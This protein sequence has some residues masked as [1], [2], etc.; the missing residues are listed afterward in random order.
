VEKGLAALMPI[1]ADVPARLMVVGDGPERRAL[2]AMAPPNVDFLGSVP[3]SEVP[4]LLRGAR[5]LVLPSI[6]YEGA[7]RTVTEAF[8]A[9]VPVVGS[10][11]GAIG[12]MVV[13][14]TTGTLATPRVRDEWVSAVSRMMDD[15]ACV[16]M[17]RAAYRTWSENFSPIRAAVQ[18]ESVYNRVVGA[19]DAPATMPVM[20]GQR[21]D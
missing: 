17:G 20:M 16:R 6:C 18:L 5:A 9:G 14:G 10:R 3:Q 21:V 13:D 11:W 7:P 8:A 19:H 1:W 2:E 12:T 15:A 4:E